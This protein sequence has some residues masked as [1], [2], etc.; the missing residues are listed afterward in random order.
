MIIRP[1]SKRR[2]LTGWLSSYPKKN[3]WVW[4]VIWLPSERLCDSTVWWPVKPSATWSLKARGSSINWWACRSPSIDL[5]KIRTRTAAS[6]FRRSK[7]VGD[8]TVR[9]QLSSGDYKSLIF[10]FFLTFYFC[11]KVASEISNPN[12]ELDELNAVTKSQEEQISSLKASLEAKMNELKS[13]LQ[14]EI[15]VVERKLK[16]VDFYRA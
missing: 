8:I 6:L 9:L 4:L 13:E 7:R 3:D 15:K 5:T 14:R 12:G 2:F 1:C 16:K 11:T 10:S